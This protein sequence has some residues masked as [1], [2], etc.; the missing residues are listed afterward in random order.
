MGGQFPPY[1]GYDPTLNPGIENSFSTATFRYG[2]SEINSYIPRLDA[3][4]KEIYFG[5]LSLAD[6]YFNPSKVFFEGGIDPILRGYSV[7]I[8]QEIDPWMVDE[9]RNILFGRIFAK[10]LCAIDVT[11][12]RDHGLMSYNQLRQA[13]N[14][15]PL[16]SFDQITNDPELVSIIRGLYNNNL[17]AVEIYVGMLAEP[18]LPGSSLGETLQASLVKKKTKQITNFR[19]IFQLKNRFNN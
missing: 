18:H 2:H 10:D 7:N 19:L 14:L 6:G 16:T 3:K 1:H 5:N 8:E 13:L 17:S 11:R 9:I 15:K 4:G 12:T